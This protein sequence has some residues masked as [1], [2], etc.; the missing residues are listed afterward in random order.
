MTVDLR[1]PSVMLDPHPPPMA[2][3][4]GSPVLQA[5]SPRKEEGAQLEERHPHRKTGEEGPQL[6]ERHPHLLSSASALLSA[7]GWA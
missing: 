7:A 3:Q 6:E 4:L 1:F 2:R 5:L